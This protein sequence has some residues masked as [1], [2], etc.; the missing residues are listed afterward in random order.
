MRPKEY[1]VRVFKGEGVLNNTVVGQVWWCTS[2]ILALGRQRQM[3]SAF[4]ASLVY[5]SSR[6]YIP[7]MV[8]SQKN[9]SI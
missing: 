4:E 9:T 5:M 2:L 3:I 6:I 7:R 1:I 8:L